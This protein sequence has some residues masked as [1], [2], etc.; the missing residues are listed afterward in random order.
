MI[1]E[2]KDLPWFKLANLTTFSSH[3]V[4]DWDEMHQDLVMPG[5]SGR[6]QR[7][8][9]YQVRFHWTPD[10]GVDPTAR[11]KGDNSLAEHNID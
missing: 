8:G 10:G 11:E 1:P 9:E 7:G 6:S 3:Q 2:E 5:C 4:V